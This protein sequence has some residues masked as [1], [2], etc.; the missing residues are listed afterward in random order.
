MHATESVRCSTVQDK[1]SKVRRRLGRK[2]LQTC[3]VRGRHGGGMGV[4][5]LTENVMLGEIG[6]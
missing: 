4:A 5:N 2:A 1:A 3:S 6:R